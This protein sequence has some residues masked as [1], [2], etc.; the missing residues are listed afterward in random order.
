[1]KIYNKIILIFFSIIVFSCNTINVNHST[2]K[3]REVLTKYTELKTIFSEE[4]ADSFYLYIRV[5]KNYETENKSYPVLYLL[6]GDI[7]FNMATSIVRYL[8][9]GN[10]VPEIIIVGIGYGTMMNDN[11]IN[12]RE[13]DYTFSKNDLFKQS[14]G[15]DKFLSF[16]K[17][18]LIPFVEK[19]Y[20]TSETRI[21]SGYSLG[22][23][24]ST[25]SLLKEKNLFSSYIAGSPFLKSDVDSLLILSNN[26]ENFDGKL[27]ITF[28]ELENETDYQIPIKNLVDALGKKIKIKEN[29]KMQIFENGTHLTCPP[30]A[31]TYGLKFIF[32]KK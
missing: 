20:R 31:L 27:F 11:K 4:V 23:L 12:F 22:G 26:L 3:K 7:S 15:A 8:Q 24:F 5:P 19:N 16:I 32:S 14:G 30:E 6:D 1:M 2:E 18:E 29:I 10:D 28:G 25:Y 21:L 17:S 13:R 9:Y